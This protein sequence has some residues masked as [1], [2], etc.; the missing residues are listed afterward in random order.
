MDTP[1]VVK[2][3]DKRLRKI[4]NNLRSII[5]KA[6]YERIDEFKERKKDYDLGNEQYLALNENMKNLK[7]ALKKSICM[8]N[9]CVL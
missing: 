8:C 6:V 7:R 9:A 1:R 2:I 3:Q 5:Y 4:R